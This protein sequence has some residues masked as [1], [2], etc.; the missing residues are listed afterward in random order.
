MSHTREQFFR[1][2][3]TDDGRYR[4]QVD[5]ETSIRCKTEM[6]SWDEGQGMP[7]MR[8]TDHMTGVS[9]PTSANLDLYLALFPGMPEDAEARQLLY[10]AKDLFMAEMKAP[11]KELQASNDPY[12]SNGNPITYSDIA[13]LADKIDY[14]VKDNWWDMISHIDDVQRWYSLAYGDDGIEGLKS[15]ARFSDILSQPDMCD[16]YGCNYY[17]LNSCISRNADEM[18]PILHRVEG[19]AREYSLNEDIS[20]WYRKSFPEDKD[21]AE[22]IREGARFKEAYKELTHC[23]CRTFDRAVFGSATIDPDVRKN[24]LDGVAEHALSNDFTISQLWKNAEELETEHAAKDM[25]R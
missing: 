21:G 18:L 23:S 25:E 19:G 10:E 9:T 1:G 22:T 4:V 5:I 12:W 14:L 15:D 6:L 16:G 20:D 17:A 8:I 2:V 7:I 13:R 3:T 11:V 24:V